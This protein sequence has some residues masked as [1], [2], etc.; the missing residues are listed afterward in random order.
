M[1]HHKQQELRQNNRWVLGAWAQLFCSLPLSSASFR[2][3]SCICQQTSM[4]TCYSRQPLCRWC[5]VF[6]RE[7]WGKTGNFQFEIPIM[8]ISR[9]ETWTRGLRGWSRGAGCL[10]LAEPGDG[11]SQ[12]VLVVKNLPA[13]EGATGDAG[14]IPG[15][16]GSPG[17]R[18]GNPLQ[19]SCLESP[20]GQTPGGL[21]TIPWGSR[22]SDLTDHEY[23]PHEE[24]YLLG[25]RGCSPFVYVAAIGEVGAWS[26]QEWVSAM[27]QTKMQRLFS[28]ASGVWVL[29]CLSITTALVPRC[30]I[31][32]KKVH[33]CPSSFSHL[34][35][36][37]RSRAPPDLRSC[38][39]MTGGRISAWEALP[40][41]RWLHT[42]LQD[43]CLSR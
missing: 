21:Q 24:A 35:A 33:S 9:C 36:P 6:R 14:S 4:S 29:M 34:P 37:E 16:G 1:H 39:H 23:K 17:G 12:V 5:H 26:P 19:Y 31:C 28:S 40:S 38:L 25:G 10:A 32:W 13:N 27:A 11:A 20:H 8:W 43:T 30:K 41:S 22:E 2:L 42:C 3:T 18:N 7:G 15:W